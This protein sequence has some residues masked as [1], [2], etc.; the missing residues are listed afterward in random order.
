V[1]EL[2]DILPPNAARL[3]GDLR[4]R[5][6]LLAARQVAALGLT[7]V[8]G[9]I[10]ESQPLAEADLL[11][12]A[13][14]SLPLLGKLV[15]LAGHRS[16]PWEPPP[17]QRV[18][19]CPL[20]SLLESRPLDLA[21][22]EAAVVVAEQIDAAGEEGRCL[23]ALDRWTSGVGPRELLAALQRV[24]HCI[25]AH[26]RL[27]PLGP[28]SRQIRDWLDT[29]AGGDAHPTLT[30]LLDDLR[31]AA[32]DTIAGGDDLDIHLAA[33]EAGFHVIVGQPLGTSPAK[34]PL[35]PDQPS[36]GARRGVGGEGVA[37]RN[38]DVIVG[39]Q[40]DASPTN[41]H[42]DVCRR[43]I[44]ARER[45]VDT[46]RFLAWQ[47]ELVVGLDAATLSPDDPTGLEAMR[48]IALAR[49]ALPAQVA[50][51]A[52]WAMFGTKTAHAALFFGASHWGLMAAGPLAAAALHL[53]GPDDLAELLEGNSLTPGSSA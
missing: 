49:L 52:P 15:E 44:D 3:E 5:L 4:T 16:P 11:L 24:L 14:A 9:T 1:A 23:V 8:A 34:P 33:A 22:E 30:A 39:R 29:A 46:G 31:A 19:A 37:Q 43:L 18:I 32:A 50:V 53:P 21:V 12:L 28:S 7:E 25:A 6:G 42:A 20:G 26:G 27:V 51:R 40:R 41:Q 35:S 13:H 38:H 48:A 2:S 45:L 10:A 47:P 17:V 36:V